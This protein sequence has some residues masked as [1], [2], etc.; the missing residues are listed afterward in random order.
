MAEMVSQLKVFVQ[1][2][3]G[4]ANRFH[5]GVQ[6]RTTFRVQHGGFRWLFRLPHKPGRLWQRSLLNHLWFVDLVT[7]H[8]L[9]MKSFGE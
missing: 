9:H 4:A 8:K 6:A 2:G 3:F 1:K 5:S 7:M